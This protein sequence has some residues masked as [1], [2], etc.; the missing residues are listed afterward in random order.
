MTHK[1]AVFGLCLGFTAFAGATSA[2]AGP[3]ITT[4]WQTID[5]SQEECL[6]RAENAI[7]VGRFGQLERTTQSRYGTLGAYTAAIRCV[8]D[9]HIA[10][11]IAAGPSRDQSPKYMEAIYPNF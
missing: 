8:S 7:G 1:F 10:F 6:Q 11:F 5:Y 4:R 9:N 2:L 3:A